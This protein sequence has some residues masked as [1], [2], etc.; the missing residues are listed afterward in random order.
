MK[1][2]SMKSSMSSFNNS[3]VDLGPLSGIIH[4]SEGRSSGTAKGHLSV[5]HQSKS[6]SSFEIDGGIEKEK[7]K[8]R[9]SERK[10]EKNDRIDEVNEE[11]EEEEEENDDDNDDEHSQ[12]YRIVKREGRPSIVVSQHLRLTSDDWNRLGKVSVRISSHFDESLAY[13]IRTTFLSVVRSRYSEAVNSGKMSSSSAPTHILY[14]SIDVALDYCHS[15]LMDWD[16]L[17]KLLKPNASLLYLFSLVDDAAYHC[18]CRSLPGL[19]SWGE[20]NYERIAVYVITNFI[21]AHQYA[22]E[23]MHYFLGGEVNEVYDIAEP[24]QNKVLEESKT[25]VCT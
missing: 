14:Y 7:E 21:Y 13:Y 5:K 24:E 1:R 12:S 18:C 6:E 2:S 17:L 23:K 16:I 9:K 8:E 11:E 19:V 3:Q 15:R 10:E 22:Q 20:V 4:S 25:L